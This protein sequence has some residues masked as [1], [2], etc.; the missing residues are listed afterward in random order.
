MAKRT[1][2]LHSLF[3]VG[4]GGVEQ[5]RL[6]LARGLD[7]DRYEQRVVCMDAFG[8]LPGQLASAGCPLARVG[9]SLSIFAARTYRD[10]LR[11]INDWQPDIV[12]GAVYEGVAMAAVGGRLGRVPVVI[13]EETSDPVGRSRAGNA[14]YRLLCGLTDRMVA[15]S[16]AVVDYLVH[17]IGVP[18]GKVTLVPNGVA[19]PLEA[20]AVA[21][22]AIKER[23]AITTGSVVIGS[24][25]RL[26]DSHKRVSDLIRAM[27]ILCERLSDP[28][29]LVVGDGEDAEMLRALAVDSGVSQRVHFC[30]YQGETAA[31]YRVMDVF[32]LAS[33]HEAFG[34]VLVEAM[35]LGLP[36]V[37]T[38]VGG[39]PTV[40]DEGVTG[41]LVPALDPQSLA[42]ALLTFCR[43]PFLRREMGNAGM[44][45]AQAEFGAERYVNAID[46]LYTRC[47][48]GRRR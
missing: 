26:E 15:V 24:I 34:L 10:V 2:V 8:A 30:G 28:R 38:R 21:V 12:H 32:A 42:A 7:S 1:K 11:L 4:S 46:A 40:V 44:Q 29:L 13:G 45:R 35:L 43:D 41:L 3:R 9:D 31:Y 18:A 20:D 37:A 22:E 14:L 23:F 27:P 5:T 33:A 48:E 16:P 6:T 47:L 36:V 25:G 39:I 17:G 19:S